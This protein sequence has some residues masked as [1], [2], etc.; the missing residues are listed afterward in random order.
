MEAAVAQSEHL[1]LQSVHVFGV[2]YRWDVSVDALL[3]KKVQSS[4]QLLDK[5]NAHQLKKKK[6]KKK[7]HTNIMFEMLG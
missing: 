7:V 1:H 2:H 4:S 6:K 3:L 5:E